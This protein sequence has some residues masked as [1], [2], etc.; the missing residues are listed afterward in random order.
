MGG[1]MLISALM[2]LRRFNNHLLMQ[3][4]SNTLYKFEYHMS[5]WCFSGLPDNQT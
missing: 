5:L 1:N 2:R 3:I 4:S